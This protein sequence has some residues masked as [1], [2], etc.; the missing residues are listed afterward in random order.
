MLLI[1]SGSNTLDM[2]KTA[3]NE[4]MLTLE[5]SGIIKALRGLTSLEEV[6]RVARHVQ[7]E[8]ITAP[9]KPVQTPPQSTNPPTT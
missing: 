2:Q 7:I 3:M 6:Y 9:V 5:Q 8:H 4:G 1:I